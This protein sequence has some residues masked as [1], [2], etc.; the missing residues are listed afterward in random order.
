M[1]SLGLLVSLVA[2]VFP[3]SAY[4][5]SITPK[6]LVG[7]WVLVSAVGPGVETGTR[8]PGSPRMAGLLDTL[9]T[10]TDST[11]SYAG[12][13]VRRWDKLIEDTLVTSEGN[14][15]VTLKDRQLSLFSLSGY[16]GRSLV[17]RRADACGL[18]P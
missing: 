15:L 16:A 7:T 3:H 5:Q 13:D 9:I 6:D 11:Y 2:F 12:G 4:A 14:F 8:S 1:K 18:K 10:R 17:Y